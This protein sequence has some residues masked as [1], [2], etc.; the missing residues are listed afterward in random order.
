MGGEKVIILKF[1]LNDDKFL[2]F[3]AKKSPCDKK[4]LK[5]VWYLIFLFYLCGVF[6]A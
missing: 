1:G 6:E 3:L 4:T 2:F 5:K